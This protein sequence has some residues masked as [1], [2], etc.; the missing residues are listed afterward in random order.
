MMEQ[1]IPQALTVKAC[2]QLARVSTKTVRR[3]IAAGVLRAFRR[4]RVLRTL[5]QDVL[6]FLNAHRVDR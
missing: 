6:D 3:W 5:T 2:S 1:P 4:G